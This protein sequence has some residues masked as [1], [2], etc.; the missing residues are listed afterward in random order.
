M[1]TDLQGVKHGNT[2]T[3]TDPVIL[4]RDFLRFGDSNLGPLFMQKCLEATRAL[5]HENGWHDST[6]SDKLC[7][8]EH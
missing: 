8:S 3:L 5:M 7:N 6:R 4:C 1:V 2:F